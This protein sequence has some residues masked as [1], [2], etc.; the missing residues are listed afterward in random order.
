MI[1][2]SCSL[3]FTHWIFFFHHGSE[4]CWILHVR[5]HDT[6]TR[7]ELNLILYSVLAV[8]NHKASGTIVKDQEIEFNALCGSL[9]IMSKGVSYSNSLKR[10]AFALPRQPV[11]NDVLDLYAFILLDCLF[12]KPLTLFAQQ[13]IDLTAANLNQYQEFVLL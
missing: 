9:S 11:F 8:Q 4:F 6:S 12:T 13:V 1:C 3:W 2:F 5:A 10:R 7:Y